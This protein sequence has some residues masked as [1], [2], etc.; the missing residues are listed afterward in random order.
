MFCSVFSGGI[1]GIESFPVGVECD[2]SAGMPVLDI[3]GFVGSEVRE[4]KERVRTA[5]RNC[6]HLL[7]VSRITIN[8]SPA[9]VKK[10][11]TGFDLPMALSILAC[12]EVIDSEELS[13]TFIAGE[14]SLSGTVRA[15]CGILPMILMAKAAGIKRC[16]IPSANA[17]EGSVVEDINVYTVSSL[18]EAIDFL[19]K[20]TDIAPLS[21]HLRKDLNAECEYESDFANVRGQ[22]MAVRGAEVAAAGLHNFLMM[23]PPGSGKTMIARSIPSIMPP[24]SEDEC[25][26]VSAIYSVRGALSS[27]RPLIVRRPF[28]PVHSSATDISLIGGGATPRPGAVSLAHKGVLFLDEVPEFQRR[29]LEALRQ[30]LEDGKVHIT[31]SRDICTFPSDCMLVAAMNPCPCG[32]YP[33]MNKCRCSDTSRTRYMSKVSGPFMDRIDICISVE[34]VTPHDLDKKDGSESSA[35]I[36]ERVIRAHNIQQARFAG[37]NIKFNSQMSNKEIEKYCRLGAAESS[38]MRTLSEKHDMSARVYY[39]ILKVARTIADLGGQRDITEN[40]IMEAVRLKA[41][42]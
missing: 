18:S 16:I 15:T 24:L 13:D 5:L 1:R 42:L 10:S 21:S 12:M 28:V 29:S 32:Y 2:I 35:M 22:R 31:R 40:S 6:G 25:L 27:D 3:V 14:L 9:N 36:R 11:G 23:G 30:P 34:K 7:P 8:L 20:K 26:E 38:L 4:A 37:T 33:D 41:G 39:R 17:G 19:Q